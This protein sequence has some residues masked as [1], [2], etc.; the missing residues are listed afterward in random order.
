M[1]V[2]AGRNP[3][4]G[5]TPDRAEAF[6]S[7]SG[8]GYVIGIRQRRVHGEREPDVP[9]LRV[10]HSAAP[11]SYPLMTAPQ[12]FTLGGNF[13]TFDRDATGDYLSVTGNGQTFPVNPYQFSINGAVYII[14]TNVQPN[15]VIGGGNVYPMTAD[16]SQFVID[17]VQYTIALKSGSLNGATISGSSTSR[18]ATSSSSRTMSISST[19]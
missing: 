4:D 11:A 19:R 3:D 5:R 12:M 7:N 10:D 6:T 18:R 8:Y 17:G 16:N 2:T 13:Y 1:T 9:V 14:N 15:T